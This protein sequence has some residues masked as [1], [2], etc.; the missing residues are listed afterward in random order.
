[1]QSSKQVRKFVICNSLLV[2]LYLSLF[3][4][5]VFAESSAGVVKN[6]N[7][8]YENKKYDDALRE[9]NKA[10]T[11]SPD[12]AVINFDIGAAQYKK[13]DYEK[14]LGS[15][16]KALIS[17]EGKLESKT[18]Y[19]IGNSKY[20]QGVLEENTNLSSAISLLKDS[21][22]YY[23]RV[24]ELDEKNKDAKFNHEFVEKKLK[25]LLDKQKQQQKQKQ[26]KKKEGKKKDKGE[27]GKE[28]Q[29]KQK[30]EKNKEKEKQEAGDKEKEKRKEEQ[31][32]REKDKGEMEKGKE[33]QKQKAEK[34]RE[35][36]EKEAK[37]LLEGYRHEEELKD[38]LKK[39]RQQG[40]YSE[41][42]KDW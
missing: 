11:K 21:L 29:Q 3:T 38:K 1:M 31:G 28:K 19:N 17:E 5:S 12:S 24:I 8:L 9:Y 42:L 40:Y 32:E 20:K 27:Q 15:F 36:S 37:M 30:A 7:K 25:V 16:T 14:A 18:N 2:T 23:K 6:A 34:S 13:G 22:D 10:L 4:C 35:M 33:E 39:T 26:D 41:V